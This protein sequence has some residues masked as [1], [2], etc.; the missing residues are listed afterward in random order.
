MNYIKQKL[1]WPSNK[2]NYQNLY[3]TTNS[4]IK[5]TLRVKTVVKPKKL[6]FTNWK[7]SSN[8]MNIA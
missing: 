8:E 6:T 4:Y 2:K 7:K 5:I 1:K 3:K